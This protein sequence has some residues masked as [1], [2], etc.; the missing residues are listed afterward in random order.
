M[1]VRAKQRLCY[2]ACLFP[3]RCVV[4]VSPHVI[5]TVG[6]L[7]VEDYISFDMVK[8]SFQI[9]LLV[10]ITNLLLAC[11]GNQTSDNKEIELL[12]KETELAK[13]EAELAKKEL[14]MSKDSN[15]NSNT[16]S[17]TP[18]PSPTPTSTPVEIKDTT[19]SVRF[20]NEARACYIIEGRIILKTQGKTFTARTGKKGFATFNKVPC[21]DA[22]VVSVIESESLYES[23]PPA[24]ATI[25]CKKSVY[26]GAF[27]I[28]YG[29][30]LSEARANYCYNLNPN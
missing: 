6:R 18:S 30:K 13:K 15:S 24:H 14:E 12:R 3:S 25:P 27:N 10:V 23:E 9:L 7:R 4:A 29:T 20:V 5:S 28:Y 2:S 16:N 26:L 8:I 11:G 22:A 1:D 21:G 17:A 19:V